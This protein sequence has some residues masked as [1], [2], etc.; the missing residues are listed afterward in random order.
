MRYPD[1]R[2]AV[3]WLFEL[4]DD[5]AAQID[6]Y[7]HVGELYVA[8][9]GGALVGHLQ[10]VEV[11]G[12]PEALELKSTAVVEDMRGQGIG[13]A[14]ADVAIERARARGR[15]RLIVATA[16]CDVGALRFYQRLGFRCWQIERDV[17]TVEAGYRTQ[18]VA[19]VPLRDRIWLDR[20]L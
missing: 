2:D 10:L 13:R 11:A 17:F 6:G 9:Y 5:S 19:G 20:A 15:A 4:A 8:R 18:L 12:A 7:L 1:D 14:L 3:R 16:T